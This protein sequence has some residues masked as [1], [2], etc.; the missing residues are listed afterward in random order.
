MIQAVGYPVVSSRNSSLKSHLA[1]L[2]PFWHFHHF[3]IGFFQKYSFTNHFHVNLVSGSAS[4]KAN[5]TICSLKTGK[6]CDGEQ[7]SVNVC[8]N[9]SQVT[10]SNNIGI[11]NLCFTDEK[12]NTKRKYLLSQPQAHLQPHK[13][14]SGNTVSPSPSLMLQ[15]T[16]GDTLPLGSLLLPN[17][18]FSSSFPRINSHSTK[19]LHSPGKIYCSTL[20][21]QMTVLEFNLVINDQ[22]IFKVSK[23]NRDLFPNSTRGRNVAEVFCGIRHWQGE[24]DKK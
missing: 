11:F 10:E 7:N 13:L 17:S 18:L 23:P 3:I 6:M 8:K 2:L 24:G 21:Y 22:E 14:L 15:E 16:E 20:M 5:L 12:T 4:G 9:Q 1:W 19:N